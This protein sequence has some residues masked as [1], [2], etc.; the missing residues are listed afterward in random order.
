NDT[1]SQV[2]SFSEGAH[3]SVLGLTPSGNNIYFTVSNVPYRFDGET[4][5]TLNGVENSTSIGIIGVYNGDVYARVT[6][7]GVQRIYKFVED[8]LVDCGI[9]VPIAISNLN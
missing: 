6:I 9:T 4:L 8:S 7:G 2:H 3:D 1:I 5:H